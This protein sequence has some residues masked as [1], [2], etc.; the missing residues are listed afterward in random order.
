M[1]NPPDVRTDGMDGAAIYA[2]LTGGAGPSA[3]TDNSSGWR[4]R[5]H[6]YAD[7]Q[8]SIEAALNKAGATWQ[9]RGADSAQSAISPLGEWANATSEASTTASGSVDAQVSS[10]SDARNAVVPMERVPDAPFGNSFWP[11]DTDHDRAIAANNELT[12]HNRTVLASYGG[13]TDT[14]VASL[15]PFTPPVPVGTDFV[16]D[17]G[18]GA[19]PPGSGGSGDVG[20]RAVDLVVVQVDLVVKAAQAA[21][22]AVQVVAAATRPVGQVLVVQEV[23]VVRPGAGSARAQRADRPGASRARARRVVRPGA[24]GARARRAD[25]PGAFTARGQQAVP[26]AVGKLHRIRARH[27]S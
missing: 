27:R 4:D 12:A 6:G 14:H 18:A 5:S 16:S 23:L 8:A 15:P 1:T 19:R 10:F 13:A 7:V 3:L 21:G 11:F 20:A 17:A 25:R 26:A 9:G 2:A 22:L 24:S